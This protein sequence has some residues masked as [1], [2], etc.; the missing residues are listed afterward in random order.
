ML[1]PGW[2]R[3]PKVGGQGGTPGRVGAELCQKGV[4]SESGQSPRMHA[5]AC[6]CCGSEPCAGVSSMSPAASLPVR[7]PGSRRRT[8]P[9]KA[10]GTELRRDRAQ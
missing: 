3:L 10:G 1:G 2:G 5:H 7:C 9:G 4:A 8:E 6:C